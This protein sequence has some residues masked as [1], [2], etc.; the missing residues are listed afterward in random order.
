MKKLQLAVATLLTLFAVSATAAVPAYAQSTCGGTKTQ[1]IA[2]SDSAG[3]GAIS[4]LIRITISVMTVLI[5]IAATGG[6]AYGALLY[7][8]AH[9][10]QSKVSSAITIIR[11]VVIGIVLHG[12]TIAIINWLVPG[13][14]IG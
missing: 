2:C 1:L 12:F 3:I 13:G 4:E 7:A 5:G 9:D 11:N 14:V 10:D 6:I 8:S